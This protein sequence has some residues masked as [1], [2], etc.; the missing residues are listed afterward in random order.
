[1]KTETIEE[2]LA[3]G[4][5]IKYYPLMNSPES[6]SAAGR[7][8]KDSRYVIVDWKEE[9]NFNYS[10]PSIEHHILWATKKGKG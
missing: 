1:M 4:G 8:E 5:K 7:K 9:F 2:Y 3:R 6:L 10:P